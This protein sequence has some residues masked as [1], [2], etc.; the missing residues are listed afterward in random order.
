MRIEHMS[1]MDNMYT[2]YTHNHYA[3]ALHN[4]LAQMGMCRHH[5]A[6]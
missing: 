3:K 6:T 1:L 5:A 4:V 2:Y